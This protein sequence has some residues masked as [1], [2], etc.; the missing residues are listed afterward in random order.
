MRVDVIAQK[1][2]I[3]EEHREKRMKKYE[4]IVY[5]LTKFQNEYRQYLYDTAKQFS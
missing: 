1:I 5:P 3:S 4:S 2:K